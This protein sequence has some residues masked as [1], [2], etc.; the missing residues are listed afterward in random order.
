M[1][2]EL[3]SNLTRPNI[4]LYN[5]IQWPENLILHHMYRINSSSCQMV[6]DIGSIT[7]F[8]V[9]HFVILFIYLSFS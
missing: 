4:R 1:D 3:A 7:D 6:A 8:L 9:T 5:Q 2:L